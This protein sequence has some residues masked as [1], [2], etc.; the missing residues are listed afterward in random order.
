MS[1]DEDLARDEFFDLEK[2]SR[3]AEADE[4]ESESVSTRRREDVRR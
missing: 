1:D 3:I 4:K 2:E